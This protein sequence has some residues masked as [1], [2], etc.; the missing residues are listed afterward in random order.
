M[1]KYLEHDGAGGAREV[2]AATTGGAPDANKIPQLDANGKF[3]AA[4]MPSGVGADTQVI[5]A[6][7]GLSAGDKVNIW[8]SA[9]AFRVR[10]ADASGGAAK[11]AHGYVLA[12]VASGANAVVYFEGTNDQIATVLTP[13]DVFLSANQPGQVTQTPPNTPGHIVQR[14]GFA[15]TST[16]LNFEPSDPITLA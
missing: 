12:A 14:V 6:S 16:S 13:G 10:R 3:P 1:T 7:E 11:K 5:Q 4:M 2:N 15:S 8:S 9:G